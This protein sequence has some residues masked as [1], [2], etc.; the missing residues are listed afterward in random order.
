MTLSG[1]TFRYDADDDKY[2]VEGQIG[3]ISEIKRVSRSRSSGLLCPLCALLPVPETFTVKLTKGKRDTFCVLTEKQKCG[4]PA[5]P[6]IE[7]FSAA[8][9]P[10]AVPP[11]PPAET[12]PPPKRSFA[13]IPAPPVPV[14]A[15]AAP[16][17]VVVGRTPD[18]VKAILGPPDR[19]DSPR[20]PAGASTKV[21]WFYKSLTVTFV[22]GKVSVVEQESRAPEL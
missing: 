4:A 10:L 9:N 3:D 7:A 1:E 21:M 13:P 20:S 15:P 5:E 11:P 18:Q 6:V 12:P 19:I 22:D 16:A 8:M 17:K 14:D 2:S